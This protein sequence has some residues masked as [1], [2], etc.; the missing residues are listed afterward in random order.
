[1]LL[2]LLVFLFLSLLVFSLVHASNLRA[3]EASESYRMSLCGGWVV[4]KDIFVSDPTSEEVWLGCGWVEPKAKC[5]W[6]MIWGI[7]KTISHK[8]I[9]LLTGKILHMKFQIFSYP[10]F[11]CG[12]VLAG[13][14]DLKK[15]WFL[16]YYPN[17]LVIDA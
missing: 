3:S 1:M 4:C 12:I 5:L 2:L 17:I 8:D 9:L 6:D 15:K 16:H 7:W 14:Q 10:G 11:L 13:K